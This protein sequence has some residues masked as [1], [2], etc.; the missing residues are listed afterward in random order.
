ML[1]GRR[2]VLGVTG[3][4]AAYKSI[5]VC[6]RLI[7][8][9]AHV[10]PILTDSALEMVGAT[11]FRALASEPPKNSLFNDDDPIPHTRLGQGADLVIVCP[12]TARILADYR[13]GRSGDLLS[14]TLIATEAPVLLAPAMH[15]EMWEHPAV[16]DN[17]EV[18]KSRGVHFVGPE[19]G[20]LAGGDSGPGRLSDPETVVEAA[21][22]ALGP[23]DLTGMRVVVSAG[24]TR[25]P[26]DPVRFLSN[27]STGKQGHAVAATAAARG[28]RVTLVTTTDLRCGPGVDRVRV[29]TAAEMATAVTEAA[30]DA[31]VVVMTAAVADFRPISVA[32]KKLKKAD[33]LE[34][35][36][37]ERTTDILAT[38]GASKRPDQ[39]LVGF[40]AETDD[41]E[42]N[43]TSKLRSKNADYIVANDVS[44]PGVG[45]G[46]DTNAVT[47]YGADGSRVGIELTAKREIA[48]ALWDIIAARRAAG[49]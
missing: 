32:D 13:M 9:G 10:S 39:I 28:A 47:V 5:E 23:D 2:V 27:H 26:V 31:D 29:D 34:S 17:V 48:S 41:L 19:Q 46:H 49:T 40:A 20:R 21:I 15:T 37:L 22:A 35:I 25:E 7:E 44:A 1:Q 16:V 42:S 8:A 36:A 14:A 3:G 11:T 38:L 43:A 24:G 6:R 4:I 33:G 12:A 45:F 30:V 18:L